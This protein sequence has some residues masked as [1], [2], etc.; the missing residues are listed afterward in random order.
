MFRANRVGATVTSAMLG[1]ALVACNVGEP[2]RVPGK[3]DAES[4]DG[5]DPD[6]NGGDG[7]STSGD[8][9]D[10]SSAGKTPNDSQPEGPDGPGTG[11]RGDDPAGG[12]GGPGASDPVA[13]ESLC[14]AA[15]IAPDVLPLRRLTTA[16]FKRSLASI[17]PGLDVPDLSL[18]APQTIDGFDNGVSSQPNNALLIDSEFAA[19]D[20]VASA[21]VDNLD[22]WA[23]CTQSTAACLN[24]LASEVARLA[25]RRAPTSGETQRLETFAQE[26]L[27]ADGFDAALHDVLQSVLLSPQTLYRTEFGAQTGALTGEEVATRLSFFLWRQAPDAALLDAAEAGELDDA[28]GLA[29]HTRRMLDDER[30]QATLEDFVGQWLKLDRI[31]QLQLNGD[32]YPE[33]TPQLRDSLRQSLESYV[34][35]A[36]WEENSLDALLRSDVVFVDEAVADLLEIAAPGDGFEMA[37]VEHRHGLLTQPGLLASTSHGSVHSPIL[38]GLKVLEG[39]LC[40]SLGA[41]PPGAAAAIEPKPEGEALTT[42]QHVE[43]THSAGSTCVGCHQLIDGVGFAFENYD[44][45]GRYVTKEDGIDVD[46]SGLVPLTS[47]IVEVADGIELSQI[48]ETSSEVRQC[49]SEHLYRYAF[50]VAPRSAGTECLIENMAATWAQNGGDPGALMQRLVESPA[51][52]TLASAEGTEQ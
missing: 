11:Q 41:P 38:R 46:S 47:G 25:F 50:G 51:F 14:D 4:G 17:F 49:L 7:P 48:V 9:G 39:F 40:V 44:A 6:G 23:S 31:S 52:T 3:G 8:D 27:E 1:L 15:D 21:A 10:P 19:I 33:L 26:A 24:Q 32:V 22:D 2:D 13:G 5:K 28:A 29:Q 18:P 34:R 16:Q 42:R 12:P 43:Q 36:L 35:W 30:G 20:T 37:H 45:L